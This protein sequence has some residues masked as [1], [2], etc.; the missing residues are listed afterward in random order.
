MNNFCYNFIVKIVPYSDEYKNQTINLI[1]TILE[2][3]F[4]SFGYE[5]P[6]LFNIPET[7]QANNW[8]FWIAI[9]KGKVVGTVGLRNYGNNRGLLKR[10]YVNKN[11]RRTGLGSKL[12]VTLVKFAKEK[13]YR[14][15]FLGT[16]EKMIAANQ[17]YLKMG[18][19]RIDSFPAE[20]PNPGDTVFYKIDL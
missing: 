12:F 10:L 8:N 15:V 16:S 9:E 14:E 19:K 2:N 11:F 3:E 7:Y 1:L 18:F 4:Y 20:I 5:R 17:F 13:N 6:D